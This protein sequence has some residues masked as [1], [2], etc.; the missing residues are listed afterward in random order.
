MMGNKIMNEV[1]LQI[2]KENNCN[3]WQV[4]T[5]EV[6]NKLAERLENLL[7]MQ[8]VSNQ[9]KLLLLYEDWINDYP[10]KKEREQQVDKFL[11]S[12]SC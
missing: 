3:E 4:S 6:A 8:N 9:R 10:T 2:C 12:N 11:K 1:I 5:L 7:N